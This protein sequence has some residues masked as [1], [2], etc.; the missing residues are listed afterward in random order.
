MES[1][2]VWWLTIGFFLA[3]LAVGVALGGLP[4]WAQATGS[5]ALLVGWGTLI[6]I[7][8][9]ARRARRLEHRARLRAEQDAAARTRELQAATRRSLYPAPASTPPPRVVA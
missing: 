1:R 3:G 6:S 4:W 7:A 9:A 2:E 5:S 8:V